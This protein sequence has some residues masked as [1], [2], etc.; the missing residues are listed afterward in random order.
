MLFIVNYA[1][2][3]SGSRIQA[4]GLICCWLALGGTFFVLAI[5][6]REAASQREAADAALSARKTRHT[7]AQVQ[8]M[9]WR[10]RGLE[11]LRHSLASDVHEVPRLAASD[12]A[13]VAA[14]ELSGLVEQ[15]HVLNGGKHE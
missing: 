13:D 8:A 10:A 7:V 15:A 4:L 2:A 14:R 12:Q 11:T 1:R 5:A 6:R 9:A 3:M